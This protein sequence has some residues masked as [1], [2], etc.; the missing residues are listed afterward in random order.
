MS[1]HIAAATDPQPPR[2]RKGSARCR[3]WLGPCALGKLHLPPQALGLPPL[4]AQGLGLAAL[5]YALW[6]E[7]FVAKAAL[8]LGTGQ[9]EDRNARYA[10]IEPAGAVVTQHLALLDAAYKVKAVQPVDMFPHTYH[11][12]NVV[13]LEKR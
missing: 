7:W 12:E 6:I 10:L 3:V 13:L 1:S 8:R 5:G 11:V 2:L 9:A 4:L